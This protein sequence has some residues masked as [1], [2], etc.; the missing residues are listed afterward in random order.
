VPLRDAY[1]VV[2]VTVDGPLAI[3]S[4]YGCLSVKLSLR[5]AGT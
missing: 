2:N 1:N 5:D 4:A 3:V